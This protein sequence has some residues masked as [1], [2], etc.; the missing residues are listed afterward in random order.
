MGSLYYTV[1]VQ[2]L[3]MD[4]LIYAMEIAFK[5]IYLHLSTLGEDRI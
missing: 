4:L 2:Q 1:L 5:I 3:L